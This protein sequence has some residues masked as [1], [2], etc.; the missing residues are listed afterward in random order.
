MAEGRRAAW[1]QRQFSEELHAE[2]L[3]LFLEPKVQGWGRP[4]RRQR[5]A[6]CV[7]Y[8][9]LV[10]P[11][12]AYTGAVL[13]EDNV[14][15]VSS[16]FAQCS[17]HKALHKTC[18]DIIYSYVLLTFLHDRWF[19]YGRVPEFVREKRFGN[20]LKDARDWAI[21]RNRYW[22]TPIPLWVSEDFEEVRWGRLPLCWLYLC[23]V[24]VA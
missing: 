8:G 16:V 7:C 3:A 10:A 19:V 23:H 9:S 17:L 13:S 2:Q 5:V 12:L 18:V 14:L 6:A 24:N 22:G 15:A 1:Q 20:W 21:S 4:E 11:R